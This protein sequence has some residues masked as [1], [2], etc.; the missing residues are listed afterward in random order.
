MAMQYAQWIVRRRW[1]VIVA[2]ILAVLAL[3]S[4][5]AKLGF[6]NDYRVFFQEGNPQVEDYDYL[7]STYNQTDGVFIVVAPDDGNVFTKDTLAAVK[8]LTDEAW[9]TPYSS[10]VDSITNFQY[11]YGEDD[12][13]VVRDLVPLPS[14]LDPQGLSSVKA[15]ALTEPL[16]AQRLISVSG[17]VTGVNITV[18][19]P[20]I[21]PDEDMEVGT[22]A[23]E[24]AAE[25]EQKYP[26]HKV[27]LSGVVMLNIA[28]Q[29]SSMNDMASL[30]PLMF[31]VVAI[32]LALFLR[33]A[34]GTFS[35]VLLILMSIMV[36]M[37]SAGFLGIQLTPPS[38]SAPTIILT[39]AVADAVHIMVTFMQSLR[40]GKTRH[41]AVV[42][43][44]RV[45]MQ[46]VF[47]TSISTVI[48][49]LSM[50]FSD[51]PPFHDLGNIV[52]VGVIG[53]FILS[54]TFLPAMLA[55]LPIKAKQLKQR[56]NNPM[57]K[58]A[59]WVIGKRRGLL[60]GFTVVTLIGISMVPL[61]ELNDEWA[62][63]FDESVQF[64]IDNDFVSQNLVGTYN[65]EYGLGSGEAGGIADPAY[66][67]KLDAFAEWAR[68]Q[69]EV[70]HVS[71]FTDI[72]K[73]LNKNLHG[74]D[75]AWYKLPQ[76][77]ELA[78]QYLL[79]Y[80]MSLPYGLDLN[81][82]INLDKSASRLT[83]TLKDQSTGEMLALEKRLA[84]WLQ[85]NASELTVHSGSPTLMFAHIGQK[86]VNSMLLGT[87]VA[88][89]L[90]SLLLMVVLKSVKIG[91]ISLIPN[92]VPAGIA[93]GIWG[94]F[95]G[96]VGMSVAMVAGMTLGIVVDDTVH[97]LSKYLRARR[98]KGQN[99][100]DAI[101]YAFNNVGVA[102][103]VTTAVLVVGF[104]ILA[105][106]SFRLNADMGA[107]TALTIAIALIIDFLLLPP[108]L[109]K[110]EEKSN[111]E[112]TTDNRLAGSVA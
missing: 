10:R 39:M 88:L 81:N 9:Q 32:M 47:I 72:M 63:Y 55:V 45:N 8:W 82:Q 64:R 25:L 21:S 96:E 90:I 93:F 68:I 41:E 92:L 99:V 15:V 54:V 94:F 42:E 57:G 1:F 61:N 89:V 73:R 52:A 5:G 70:T 26:G 35:S 24:L 34:F 112:Q 6:T 111:E 16:L 102:L 31:A 30:V 50:N 7:Q 36:G 60:T 101:R 56:S 37:G 107:V 75:E 103:A 3:A 20:G 95:V 29:E 28:F 18:E 78:A 44:L 59:N 33:S 51:A 74:D 43:S 79:L 83:V 66:L 13:L 76:D 11:T 19:R 40:Q 4:G 58:L 85:V 71:T 48:G 2:S 105:S 91:L 22:F 17:H 14:V 109:M 65:I 97:F 49:F 62:S 23:R 104:I 110:F 80:E 98:E 27:Y 69:P 106:S 86:N 77:R 84:E 46:P 87:T 67:K 108:L 12:D 38:A 100:E 53:A